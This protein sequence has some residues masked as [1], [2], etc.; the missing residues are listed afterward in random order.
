[1]PVELPP[2][3]PQLM[4]RKVSRGQ[5]ERCIDAR[6]AQVSVTAL[7]APREGHAHPRHSALLCLGHA[8]LLRTAELRS[9]CVHI[10]RGVAAVVKNSQSENRHTV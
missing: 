1:M 2:V 10:L 8:G 5:P 6:L 3:A 4:M 9:A 7:L